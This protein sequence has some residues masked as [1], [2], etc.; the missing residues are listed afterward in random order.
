MADRKTLAWLTAARAALRGW[1]EDHY[2][3]DLPE[4]WWALVS[5]SRTV[6]TEGDVAE[7][8]RSVCCW[9]S[10]MVTDALLEIDSD[11]PPTL[12][13]KWKRRRRRLEVLRTRETHRRDPDGWRISEARRSPLA[14]ALRPGWRQSDA[15]LVFLAAAWDRAWGEDPRKRL[16]GVA[17]WY[18]SPASPTAVDLD[19]AAAGVPRGARCAHCRKVLVVDHARPVGGVARWHLASCRSCW[20]AAEARPVEITMTVGVSPP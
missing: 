3:D 11:V 14:R 4:E 18:R 20:S 15:F 10:A 5:A 19:L 1:A 12:A 17:H 6:K 9:D 2:Q 8:L 13:P 7:V 16:V